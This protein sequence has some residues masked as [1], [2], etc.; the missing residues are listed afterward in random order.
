MLFGFSYE[1]LAC[2]IAFRTGLKFIAKTDYTFL[3]TPSKLD[4]TS[5]KIGVGGT[6][7]HTFQVFNYE[8]QAYHT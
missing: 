1:F 3:H 7:S 2:E 4:L 5:R 6:F 8:N